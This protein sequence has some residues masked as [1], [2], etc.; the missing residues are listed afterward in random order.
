MKDHKILE[1]FTDRQIIFQLI[2]TQLVLLTIAIIFG[3]FVFED[4]SII[5]T[6]FEWNGE[7]VWGIIAGIVIVLID[8]VLMKFLPNDYYDDGGVNNRIFGSQSIVNIF[9][10]AFIIA[11]CEEI[12]FRGMI[13]TALG[14]WWASTLFSIVHIRY[15]GHWYLI[16]NII[17]LSFTIGFMYEWTNNLWVTIVAHFIIDFVLGVKIRG[18]TRLDR[19]FNEGGN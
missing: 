19:I 2:A 6:I 3:I 9:V 14:I 16:V 15:F 13:Q 10:L 4:R 8:L 5:R 7:I 17:L 11:F 1:G 18:K 12:L